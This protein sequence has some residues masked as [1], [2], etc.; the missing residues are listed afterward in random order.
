[1]D[2]PLAQKLPIIKDKLE[3]R[4][5]VEG[6]GNEGKIE[7]SSVNNGP[8]FVPFIW[9]SGWMGPN[10]KTKTA[11]YHD[12]GHRF[13]GTSTL[14]RIGEGVAAS[15]TAENASKTKNR[16]SYVYSTALSERKVTDIVSNLL[17]GVEFERK[18]LSVER[19]TK[20][21]FDAHEKDPEKGD[22][23]HNFYIPF[24]F[25]EGYGGDFRDISAN[26]ELGLK[27]MSEEEVEDEFRKA[28]KGMG[29]V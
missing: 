6:L 25:G 16:T 28:L 10:P 18:N 23:L 26:K 2:N 11:T 17:G 27:E 3:I 20:E 4:A 12:G 19:L 13:V 29:L 15:L 21:A 22:H 1:M 8:F 24:C 7:W 14:E 5:F 9:L